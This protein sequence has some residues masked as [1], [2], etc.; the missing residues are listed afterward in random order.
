MNSYGPQED[1]AAELISHFWQKIEEEVIIAKNE[2]CLILIQLDANA[3]IGNTIIR[4]DIHS[5]SGNG[6]LLWEFVNRQN[7]SIVNAQDKCC[8][9]VTRERTTV[10]GVEKSTIDY[11]IVCDRMNDN[12]DEML[13]DEARKY[14]LTNYSVKKGRIHKTESDHNLLV[15]KFSLNYSTK[16]KTIRKEAFKLYDQLGQEAFFRET[17]ITG[18]LSDIFFQDNCF[19]KNSTLFY[20]KLNGCIRK[21]FKKVR[22]VSGRSETRLTYVQFLAKKKNEYDLALKKC[23]CVDAHRKILDAIGRIEECL[24]EN[25]AKEKSIKIKD[26]VQSVKFNG[27]FSQLKLWKL[28]QRLCPR[29]VDPPMAK[30]DEAGNLITTPNRLKELYNQTYK[31]RLRNRDIK[32]EL[33]DVYFL[34]MELWESRMVELVANKS[35]NWNLKDLRLSCKSLKVNKTTDPNGMINELFKEGVIGTD[36]EIALLHLFNGIKSSFYIPDYLLRQNISTIYKNKGSRLELKNDRGIFILT[37]IKKILDKLIFIDK[38]GDIE[39]NMS[40]SNIGA[41][42]NKQ[43]KDHLFI[44]HGIINSVTQDKDVACIDIQIYDIEQ[45]FDALWLEEC[46]S[47]MF[48]SLSVQK[49]DD[50]IALLYQSSVRNLVSVNT[51][52]GLTERQNIE[53]IV[54]QGGTWG[55]LMCSNSIDTI[56]KQIQ[57]SGE[58][59]YV[60][61]KSVRIPPLAMVDDIMAVSDCGV[62]SI[63]L[64]SYINSKIEL[65][66]LRFHTPDINGK[67]K[68]HKLHVG[69][70]SRLCPLL[71]VHGTNMQVVEHDEYLGDIICVDGKPKKNIEKRI[72]RGYGIISEIVNILNQVSFGKHYL[73]IAFLLREAIFLASVLSN[74]EVL[75]N[76]TKNDMNDFDK[77]DLILLRRIFKAPISTPKEAFFLETGVIPAS[78]EI[79]MKR[80]KYLHYLAK[81]S[82]DEM[83]SKFFMTQWRNPSKGDWVVYV[84]HDLKDLDIPC[85][86]DYIAQYSK[87]SFKRYLKSK[88]NCFTFRMMINQKL[89]HSKLS[90]LQYSSLE[91]QSYVTSQ[92]LTIEEVRQ[93][94]RFR[95]RMSNFWGNYRSNE[96]SRL[97]PMCKNHPDKQEMLSECLVIKVNFKEPQKVL[98]NVYS[99]CVTTESAKLVVKML[100]FREKFVI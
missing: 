24:A 78:I 98:Q 87:H 27:T 56:G 1:D 30:K 97:C 35:E 50:K 82:K 15:C 59:L 42:K 22:I 64:N 93:V 39:S 63:S 43:V 84:Q 92:E 76:F 6:K 16:K 32:E 45:A 14:V 90:C 49:R 88:V 66:K 89:Q 4:D 58:M 77:L 57:N 46:M 21:C 72:A 2:G 53:S 75:Y 9:T 12:L 13:V 31:H 18:N 8:G 80:V 60:Y 55:P 40:E 96:G 100:E 17:S 61:K 70:P 67:T 28:K 68:C 95:V 86:L 38:Q 81:K 44:L 54:Q 5:M 71:K 3:K 25:I 62:N 7:L 79:K 33:M 26:Y 36:L 37:A 74:T 19:P 11:V 20:K 91:T 85:D 29:A 65:K 52:H 51:P 73:E 10:L 94:F 99:Q 83:L 41:R 23:S 34:K 69:K 48:D 47:D